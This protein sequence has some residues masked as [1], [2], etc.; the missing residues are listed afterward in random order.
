MDDQ[1]KT[2]P[3]FAQM[4]FIEQFA[5]SVTDVTSRYNNLHSVSYSPESI[6]GKPA[7]YPCYGDYPETYMLVSTRSVHTKTIPIRFL[8]ANLREMVDRFGIGPEALHAAGPGWE[9]IA[10]LYNGQVWTT[11][12]SY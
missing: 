1:A 6:T 9:R 3:V 2:N 12:R 11:R 5:E 4:H 8:L 7:I 10:G